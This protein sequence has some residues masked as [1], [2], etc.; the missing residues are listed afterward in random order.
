MSVEAS[1]LNPGRSGGI[2]STEFTFSKCYSSTRC[3]SRSQANVVL[4]SA[5][6]GVAIKNTRP[7]ACACMCAEGSARHIV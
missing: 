4:P 3:R 7:C 6:M 2:A 1:G 5:Y